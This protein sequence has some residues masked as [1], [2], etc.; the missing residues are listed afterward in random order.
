MKAVYSDGCMDVKNVRKWAW[1][2]KS[3]CADEMS[4]FDENSPGRPISATCDNNKSRVDAMI[5]VN[6]RIKQ[7]D[8]AL[9]LGIRQKRM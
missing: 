8:I 1:C 6:R 3:C 4:I 7:R 2:A 5:E 9:E